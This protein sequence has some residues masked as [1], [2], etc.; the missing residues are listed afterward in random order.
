MGSA[1]A[2]PARNDITAANVTLRQ[3]PLLF[4]IIPRRSPF[5]AVVLPDTKSMIVAIQTF[6]LAIG[7]DGT[8]KNL[9]LDRFLAC[10]KPASKTERRLRAGV[11]FF[12][13]SCFPFAA[14]HG[15]LS[16]MQH[17]EGLS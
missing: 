15:I 8:I 5:L 6:S 3:V 17:G 9:L 10:M 12:W 4:V 14:V 2:A 1:I 7:G 16:Q 13:A 11:F